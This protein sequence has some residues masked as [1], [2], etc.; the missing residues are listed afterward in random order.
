MTVVQSQGVRPCP[1]CSKSAPTT[2]KVEAKEGQLEQ[3]IGIGWCDCGVVWIFDTIGSR[4]I[5][6]IIVSRT[7]KLGKE[8]T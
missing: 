3:I 6:S 7:M 4:D 2:F 8:N 1:K 5:D